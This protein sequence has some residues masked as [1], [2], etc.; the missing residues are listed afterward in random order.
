[1]TGVNL[2]RRFFTLQSTLNHCYQWWVW[3]VLLSLPSNVTSCF[4]TPPFVKLFSVGMKYSWYDDQSSL[5]AFFGFSG[6]ILL[7]QERSGGTCREMTIISCQN[8]KSLLS[9][10]FDTFLS[11]PVFQGVMFVGDWGSRAEPRSPLW[12]LTCFLTSLMMAVWLV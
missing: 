6:E 10:H 12:S 7:T 1:M 2:F 9:N 4:L 5:S 11:L 8:L 3:R